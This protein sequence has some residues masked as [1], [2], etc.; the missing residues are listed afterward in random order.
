M[1]LDQVRSPPHPLLCAH[2]PFPLQPAGVFGLCGAAATGPCRMVEN[3]SASAVIRDTIS[4]T[5]TDLLRRLDHTVQNLGKNK[6]TEEAPIMYKVIHRGGALVRAGY[7][8]SSSQVHQLA[9]GEVATVV[10]LH[11]RRARIVTPVEGWVSTETKEGVMIMKPTSLPSSRRQEAFQVAFEQKFSRLKAQKEASSSFDDPRIQRPG[12]PARRTPSNSPSPR[13]RYDDRDN[14]RRRDRNRDGDDDQREVDWSRSR[15]GQRRDGS[16]EDDRC[17]N[18][19]RRRDDDRRLDDD[20]RR[21]QDQDRDRRGGVSQGGSAT[22]PVFSLGP[23]S[24]SDCPPRLAPPDSGAFVPV[25]APPSKS[26]ARRPQDLFDPFA[27]DPGPHTTSD[28]ASEADLLALQ[29]GGTAPPAGGCASMVGPTNFGGTPGAGFAWAAPG[30]GSGGTQAIDFGA[31]TAAAPAAG[32]LGP[33]AAGSTTGGLAGTGFG[34]VPTYGG[35]GGTLADSGFGGAHV[36]GGFGAFTGAAPATGFTIGMQ[37]AALR[38]AQV[39]DFG[40]FT[41]A[42]PAVPAVRPSGAGS[43]GNP[44]PQQPVPQI[45]DLMTRAMAGVANLS[46]EQ[47][48]AQSNKPQGGGGVPMGMMQQQQQPFM[49]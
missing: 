12:Q 48:M 26:Q 47:R 23:P 28:G 33:K 13:S 1:L 46:F 41:A 10:E 3:L 21:D 38:S 5:A 34:G 43:V 42:G 44:G 20:R 15:N 37:D 14:G 32:F 30:S 11:G 35:L 4:S 25:M 24:S 40:A 19:H 29:A 9:A 39:A 31:F 17:R 16:R 7:D 49:R 18:D 6:P 22:K 8:T 2:P 45:D 27:D 36:G